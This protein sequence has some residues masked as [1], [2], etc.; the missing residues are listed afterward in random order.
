MVRV[1]S[2]SNDYALRLKWGIGES[3]ED[4]LTPESL[5]RFED[6]GLNDLARDAVSY[7]QHSCSGLDRPATTLRQVQP[8]SEENT[9]EAAPVLV[10]T[11]HSK[12]YR[13]L[14]RTGGRSPFRPCGD[15]GASS[16]GPPRGARCGRQNRSRD[17]LQ[18]HE[19]NVIHTQLGTEHERS[20]A[21]PWEL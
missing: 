21:S 11:I 15:L 7:N 10:F 20:W 6:I 8:G 9:T 4:D 13:L 16:S 3:L 18:R 12:V 2:G 17:D 19:E 14:I 1:P 5:Q